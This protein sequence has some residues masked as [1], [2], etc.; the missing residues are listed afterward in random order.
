MMVNDLDDSES[1]E[2]NSDPMKDPFESEG[3]GEM[4]QAKSN[5]PQADAKEKPTKD[6]SKDPFEIDTEKIKEIMAKINIKAPEWA[7]E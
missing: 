6:D 4:I 5:P 3:W 7:S 1:E 2:D